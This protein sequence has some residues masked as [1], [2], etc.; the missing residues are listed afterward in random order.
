MAIEFTGIGP[1]VIYH[2]KNEMNIEYAVY[3]NNT[4]SEFDWSLDFLVAYCNPHT[5]SLHC[6]V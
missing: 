6:D 2:K 3:L 4:E 5:Y 1:S